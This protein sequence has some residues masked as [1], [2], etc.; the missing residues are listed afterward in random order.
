[1]RILD[2]QEASYHRNHPV[3]LWIEK[4][5]RE[6]SPSDLGVA[7]RLLSEKQCRDVEDLIT[8]RYGDP[9]FKGKRIT[10]WNYDKDQKTMIHIILYYG[11]LEIHLQCMK[12]GV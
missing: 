7:Y 10:E 5:L 12:I 8:R 3:I 11:A 1:M 4:Y 6:C 9:V 2:L